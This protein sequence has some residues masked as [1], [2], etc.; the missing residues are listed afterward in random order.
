MSICGLSFKI[1]GLLCT[2]AISLSEVSAKNTGSKRNYDIFYIA[3]IV[4]N[5][6]RE[7]ANIKTKPFMPFSTSE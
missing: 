1:I 4:C 7:A 3:I 5:A 6:H 2:F